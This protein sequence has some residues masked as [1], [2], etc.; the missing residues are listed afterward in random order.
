MASGQKVLF[1]PPVLPVVPVTCDYKADKMHMSKIYRDAFRNICDSTHS[2]TFRR[3][4]TC[5]VSPKKRFCV[6]PINAQQASG[7][8]LMSGLT[9]KGPQVA[10]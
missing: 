3:K 2:D 7:S 1:V 5:G 10:Q 8:I 9:Q 6:V 4:I